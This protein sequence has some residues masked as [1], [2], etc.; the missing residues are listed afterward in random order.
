MGARFLLQVIFSL[1]GLTFL[2]LLVH[3]EPLSSGQITPFSQSKE[4]TE[5]PEGWELLIFKKIPS[6]TNYQLVKD[7][8]RLV[9]KATSDKTASGLTHHLRIDLKEA[10]ILVWRWKVADIVSKG[11]V[12]TKEGDDYAARIYVTFEYDPEKVGWKKKAKYKIGKLL[13]GDIPIAAINYIWAN[14]TPRE[15][16]VDNAYTNLVKMIVLEN[17]EEKVGEWVEENRNVYEDY[18]KAFGEE[19]P[20]VNGIAIM[21]DTDNTGGAATAFYGDIHFRQESLPE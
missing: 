9:V 21:T 20:L 4:G 2:P 17:R 1:V 19:P 14:L 16:F 6:R 8:N 12:R 3:A 15:T 18:R 7:E 11:D 13:F 10:P 5:L